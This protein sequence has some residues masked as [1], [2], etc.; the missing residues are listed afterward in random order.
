MNIVIRRA[1]KEDC[2]RLMELVN[3]LAVYEKA[4]EEVTVSLSH[5]IESGFGEHAGPLARC[6]RRRRHGLSAILRRP[7]IADAPSISGDTRGTE[8]RLCCVRS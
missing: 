6:V 3:E 1:V 8:G 4:P 2:E 5:F 7:A